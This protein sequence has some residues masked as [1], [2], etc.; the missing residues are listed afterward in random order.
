MYDVLD[1]VRVVEVSAWLFAPDAGAI[2]AD[3][4]ADV[5]KIETVDGGDPYREYFATGAVGRLPLGRVQATPAHGQ[6]TE[7]L[8]LDLGYS[9]DEIADLKRLGAIL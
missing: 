5:V 7:E 6:Q 3:W 8:L 2:L 9:W 4:G 1:G